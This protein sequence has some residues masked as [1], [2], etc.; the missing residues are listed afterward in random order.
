MDLVCPSDCGGGGFRKSD[1]PYLPG[2]DVLLQRPHSFLD[3]NGLVDAVHIDQVD[4]RNPEPLEATGEAGVHVVLVS[5]RGD[6]AGERVCG[7]PEL[8][9]EEDLC[10]D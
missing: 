8:C 10:A 9:R 3:R 6:F 1:V 2:I 4:H 7:D 5:A